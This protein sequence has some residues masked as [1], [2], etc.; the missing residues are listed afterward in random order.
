MAMTARQLY[1]AY[2]VGSPYRTCVEHACM[3]CVQLTA[4]LSPWLA[5]VV[6]AS[7]SGWN[8]RCDASMHKICICGRTSGNGTYCYLM[9]PPISSL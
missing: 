5:C 3:A 1:G 4:Q 2:Q 9:I 8:Q 7:Y 6:C